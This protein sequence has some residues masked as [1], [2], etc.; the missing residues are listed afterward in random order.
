MSD[1]GLHEERP[2]RSDEFR[3]KFMQLMIDEFVRRLSRP[4]LDGTLYRKFIEDWLYIERPMIDRFIGA[5]FNVQFEGP[6]VEIDSAHYPL[7]GFIERQIKWTRISPADAFDLRER[8]REVVDRTVRDW[9]DG[10][11]FEFIPAHPKKPFTNR[12]AAD[13]EA[14]QEI[15]ALAGLLPDIEEFG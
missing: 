15:R 7:G 12:A 5:E 3:Q 9:M 4:G 13:A 2:G 11:V 14:V 6:P 1:N 8:L 10:R